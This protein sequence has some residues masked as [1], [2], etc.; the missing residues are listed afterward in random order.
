MTGPLN[1]YDRAYGSFFSAAQ[2]AVRRETYGQDIGQTSWMT[3]GEWLHFADELRIGANTEVL[4]VGSGSGG[5]ALYLA[6][7]RGCRVTGVD[8]NEPGIENGRRLAAMRKLSGRARFLAVTSGAPLPFAADSF[9]ALVSNDVI[10]HIPDRLAALRDWHRVLRAGGRLLFSDAAVVTGPISNEE[11]ALRSSIGF[12]I[13]VPA[14][15]NERLLAEAGFALLSVEN[16]TSSP[17]VIAQRR[18]AARERNR[19]ALIEQEGE[20]EFAG[21]QRYLACASRL[22][23]EQ[24]L[25]RFVYLAEKSRE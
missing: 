1:L 19:E 13:F 23:A 15:E 16:L 22:A 5:P 18:R 17:A 6:E 11:L 9:D 21:L 10:C 24:R 7:Q 4:E 3:A 12:F 25:S 8:V 20:R 2:S 14:G